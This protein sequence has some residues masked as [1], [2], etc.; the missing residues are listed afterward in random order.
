MKKHF[1]LKLHN[2]LPKGAFG[3]FIFAL[4]ESFDSGVDNFYFFDVRSNDVSNEHRCEIDRILLR[5]IFATG[6]K[7]LRLNSLKILEENTLI[8]Q[9][10]KFW[11]AHVNKQ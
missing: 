3:S 10:G 2:L 1:Q 5:H 7:H 8:E 11:K 4:D 6:Q 9:D